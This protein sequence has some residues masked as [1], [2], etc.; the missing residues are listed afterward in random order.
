MS[1]HHDESSRHAHDHHDC[2]S[3]FGCGDQQGTGVLREDIKDAAFSRRTADRI[4]HMDEVDQ[5]HLDAYMTARGRA[6]RD[7][8]RASGF[9]ALLAAV[10]PWFGKLA[11]AAEG[12]PT[13]G[14]RRNDSGRVHVVECTK[15]TVR[16]GVF[17]ANLS[18]IL[19]ID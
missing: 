13:T 18:P 4:L 6:R 16:L 15:E 11:H 8:V 9:M 5:E 2:G 10:E 7:L 1:E 3:F 19:T 12:A 14:S 17:D